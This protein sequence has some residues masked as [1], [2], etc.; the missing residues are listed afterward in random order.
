MIIDAGEGDNM[1]RFIGWRFGK[2]KKRFAFHAAIIT[3]P[4]QDHYKGFQKLFEQQLFSFE[5]VYHNGI[6]ERAGGELFGPSDPSGRY[7]TDLKTTDAEI[8]AL[9]AD[10][11]ARDRKMYPKLIHTAL[12]NGRVNGV[13][14]LSTRHGTL[15]GGRAWLP[16]FSPGESPDLTIEILGPVVE[17]DRNGTPRLR[18]F[19]D[20]VGFSGRDNGKTKN[21]HSVLLRLCYRS[22]TLLFGGDLNRPAEEFLLRHYGGIANDRPLAEAIERARPRLRSDVM[23]SC[24]HGSADVTD[25]FVQTVDP[26]AFVVSSGDQESHVHPRPDLLG[27][28]GRHGRGEAP[29]ILCTEILRS[30]REKE[31]QRQLQ[32]LRKLDALIEAAEAPEP[33]MRAMRLERSEIQKQLTKR[34][35]E[36]YGAITLR[37][38]GRHLAVAFRMEKE[39]EGR[40]PKRWQIYWFRHDEGRG[41]IP[42]ETR[43]Q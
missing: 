42:E 14:M 41:F 27:R 24:H 40:S 10:E 20:S 6:A 13:E 25:E 35:V 5:K 17:P 39:R 8:R 38:D 2:L 19:G 37:T 36:V 32:R 23:K 18:W 43:A 1:Y 33:E 31:D 16:G 4:D 34:N 26:F 28:L 15:E 9:Y 3:H 29:L 7:L 30:S 22:F 12:S 11:A 21:G